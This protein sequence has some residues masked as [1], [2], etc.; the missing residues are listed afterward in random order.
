MKMLPVYGVTR[1]EPRI[2]IGI[3]GYK[4]EDGIF[5]DIHSLAFILAQYWY[6]QLAR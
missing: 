6:P 3:I 5:R 4:D 1:Y 2:T